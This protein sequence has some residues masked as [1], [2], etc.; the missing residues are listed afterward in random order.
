MSNR[1]GILFIVAT[2]IGN[3][4]DITFRAVDTLRKVDAVI[5]EEYKPGSTLLKK[6]GIAGKE[7][8]LLNEHNEAEQAAELLPRLLNGES[9]ALISDC[10]TPVFSDPGAYL[11]Q[12]AAS[13]GVTVSPVPGASSLM[14]VLSLLD[15]RIEN[16]VFA[17]F[18]PREPDKRR[19][20]L[21]R[22]RGYRMPI[23]VMDTPYRLASL[24]DDVV[25]VFGKG[26]WILVGFDLTLPTE[27]VYR[28]EVE[29]VQKLT[30]GKK[31]EFVLVIGR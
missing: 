27:K 5:C 14:A 10:G 31:G 25:K 24:L 23:V 18:L 17:G 6:L 26:Q 1:T 4:D 16:F 29:E 13:S 7:L 19:R 20:E 21:T 12:L 9:F 30:G 2:P 3:L 8:I 15:A 22:Y 28:G 11:I